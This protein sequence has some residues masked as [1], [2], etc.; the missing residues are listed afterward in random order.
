M[1]VR[2]RDATGTARVNGAAGRRTLRL[3][4]DDAPLS[5]EHE[6]DEVGGGGDVTAG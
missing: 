4:D 5:V 3:E 1:V 2:P 6:G